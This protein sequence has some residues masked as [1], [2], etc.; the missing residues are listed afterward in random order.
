MNYT[1]YEHTHAAKIALIGPI[2]GLELAGFIK[3]NRIELS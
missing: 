2:R 1:K 3:F